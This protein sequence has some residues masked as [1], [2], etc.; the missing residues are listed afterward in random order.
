MLLIAECCSWPDASSHAV[1]TFHVS[2]LSVSTLTHAQQNI[3][4]YQTSAHL[5]NVTFEITKF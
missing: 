1:M 2:W 3:S 4:D 5:I